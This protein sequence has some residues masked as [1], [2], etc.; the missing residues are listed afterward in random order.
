MVAQCLAYHISDLRQT[1]VMPKSAIM[2]A[3]QPIP[4]HHVRFVV[5]SLG[6]ENFTSRCQ[7]FEQRPN[8][9]SKAYAESNDIVRSDSVNL[10]NF[11]IE[12]INVPDRKKCNQKKLKKS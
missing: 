6:P 7:F 1:V 9:R 10:N 8:K 4:L 2:A 5:A 11:G 3:A 12:T